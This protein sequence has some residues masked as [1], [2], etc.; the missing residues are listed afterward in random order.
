M[1]TVGF[2]FF[3]GRGTNIFVVIVCIAVS[4]ICLHVLLHHLC[5]TLHFFENLDYC[6]EQRVALSDKCVESLVT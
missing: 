1:T 2:S 3:S 5:P 4:F 6:C